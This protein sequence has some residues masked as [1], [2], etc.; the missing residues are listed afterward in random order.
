MLGRNQKLV[1]ILVVLR[2]QVNIEYVEAVAGTVIT[3]CV[4][5]VEFSQALQVANY[6]YIM[7]R[8]TVISL[9]VQPSC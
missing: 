2:P 4:L 3:Q 1:N 6:I 5:L 8:H 7:G 9:V